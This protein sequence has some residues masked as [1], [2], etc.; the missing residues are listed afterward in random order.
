LSVGYGE[1]K[2]FADNRLPK[3]FHE[4]KGGAERPN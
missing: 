1:L 4:P 2:N 3:P